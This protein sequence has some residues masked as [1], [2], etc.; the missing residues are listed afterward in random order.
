M[1]KSKKD[2][3]N[4][5][6]SGLRQTKSIALPTTTITIFNMPG[7]NRVFLP[8]LPRT[9]EDDDSIENGST[10][11]E[12]GFSELVNLKCI[13]HSIAAYNLRARRKFKG[14]PMYVRGGAAMG[15]TFSQMIP[16]IQSLPTV[17][18]SITINP[19]LPRRMIDFVSSSSGYNF[20]RAQVVWVVQVPAPLGTA[21]ILRAWAPELDNTTE[22]RGVR[23]KPQ[24]NTAI[25]F[26]MDWSSDIPLVKN[27]N[28]VNQ[29]RV[30]QSGLTLRIQCV[31]DNSTDAVNTPL[32][33][34]IWCCVYN[35]SLSSQKAFTEADREG[36]AALSSRPQQ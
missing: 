19:V 29:V 30:G 35:V 27:V 33:A 3:K 21:L 26:K 32:N 22:T 1:N 14:L 15:E 8:T 23:W 2:N 7:Q 34:T 24:S 36:L 25:A 13:G 12:V 20:I 9:P 5:K 16:I 18:N 6:K 10:V 4:P 17:G 28:N 11:S 31:E